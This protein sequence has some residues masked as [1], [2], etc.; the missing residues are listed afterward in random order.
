MKLTQREAT[1][2]HAA[3]KAG[4]DEKTARKYRRKKQLPS[5]MRKP[6]RGRTRPDPFEGAWDRLRSPSPIPSHNLKVSWDRSPGLNSQCLEIRFRSGRQRDRQPRD[7]TPNIQ[8]RSTV[9]E[10]H[11]RH[12]LML[13]MAPPQHLWRVHKEPALF[14]RIIDAR[15]AAP[16]KYSTPSTTPQLKRR[17]LKDMSVRKTADC[18]VQKMCNRR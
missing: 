16:N 5:Q 15:L 8:S 14:N 4:M 7:A 12:P 9:D 11:F 2:S 6:Q 3:A 18:V 17:C 1:L 13:S 10:T